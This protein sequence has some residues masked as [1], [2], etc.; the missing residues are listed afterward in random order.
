MCGTITLSV[1]RGNLPVALYVFDEPAWCIIGRA[2]DCDIQIPGS[3][4]DVSRHHCCLEVEPPTIRVRDLGSRNGTYVNGQLVGQRPVPGWPEA[5]DSN[6]G[7]TYELQDGDEVGLGDV[8]F[9]VSVL[10]TGNGDHDAADHPLRQAG[11][12][13]IPAASGKPSHLPRSW[14]LVARFKESRKLNPLAKKTRIT[15][16]MQTRRSPV[17]RLD[18]C[19]VDR[20]FSS[21]RVGVRRLQPG[22]PPTIV[23]TRK[24]KTVRRSI[25]GHCPGLN[26][27]THLRTSTP[28]RK[29][30]GPSGRLDQN[31]AAPRRNHTDQNGS[32]T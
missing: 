31:P 11:G 23:W 6:A 17:D 8:R 18:P 10:F 14:D 19:L 30:R 3:H 9:R 22:S 21:R 24:G 27:W 26:L 32:A 20:L 28:S 15:M 16:G 7:A 5:A 12:P 4:E 29:W 1:I 25:S 13:R 2:E